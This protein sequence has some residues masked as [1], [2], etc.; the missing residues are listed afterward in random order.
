MSFV[1]SSR[2]YRMHVITY[3]HRKQ[4]LAIQSTETVDYN[5]ALLSKSDATNVIRLTWWVDYFW[6]AQKMVSMLMLTVPFLDSVWFIPTGC[7]IC[8]LHDTVLSCFSETPI[9]QGTCKMR[10]AECGE[11]STCKLRG[12]VRGVTLQFIHMNT[13]QTSAAASA[14]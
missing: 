9:F 6:A 14:A 11:A 1:K 2:I 7:S 10:G 8:G 4:A 3:W 5:K 12:K 13:P